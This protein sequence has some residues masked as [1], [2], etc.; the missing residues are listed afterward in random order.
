MSQITTLVI[1]D[2]L[3]LGDI[4]RFLLEEQGYLVDLIRDG[5]DA[6]QVLQTLVTAPDLVILDM[7][8]PGVPGAELLRYLKS[9]G[10]FT[11][12]QVMVT[13]ADTQL[14]KYATGKA[15]LVCPKPYNIEEFL[16]AVARL[17]HR[18]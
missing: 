4:V 16:E 7:H 11:H 17:S 14:S 2:D 9:N 15:D 1:E 8:L 3:D 12:T 10:R 13:T 5:S 6:Q 18:E